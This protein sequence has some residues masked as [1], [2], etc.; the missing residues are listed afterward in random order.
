MTAMSRRR[1]CS[2]LLIDGDLTATLSTSVAIVARVIFAVSPSPQE[3]LWL[4][5]PPPSAATVLP[6]MNDALSETR[7][8][9]A[10]AIFT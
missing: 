4:Q 7:N 1:C 10:E 3:S 8:A 6:V 5:G 2:D 9:T